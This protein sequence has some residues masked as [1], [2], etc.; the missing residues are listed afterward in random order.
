M[1]EV[2]ELEATAMEQEVEKAG[3]EMGASGRPV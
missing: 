3:V 1:V 2:R